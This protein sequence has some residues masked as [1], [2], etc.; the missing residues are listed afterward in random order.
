[1]LGN[2]EYGELPIELYNDA[3]E[4]TDHFDIF[5]SKTRDEH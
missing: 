3:E 5:E 2:N 1:M 4:T